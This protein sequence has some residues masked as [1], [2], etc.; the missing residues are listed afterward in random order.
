MQKS[1]VKQKQEQICSFSFL[2]FGLKLYRMIPSS[3]C[4]PE[5][6]QLWTESWFLWPEH[7][8][9]NSHKR[10]LCLGWEMWRK[11]NP[12]TLLVGMQTG[13]V[14]MENTMKSLR[15]L[16]TKTTIWSSNFTPSYTAEEN[17]NTN[18]KRHIFEKKTKTL[19]WKDTMFKTALFTKAKIWKQPKCSSTD[20]WITKTHTY[21]NTYMQWNIT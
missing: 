13:A 14:T 7:P 19:I 15:K 3:L 10:L 11:G 17:E 8:K 5:T 21:T 6:F 4:C 18:L 1:Q 16:K 9:V 20:V 12:P 2:D